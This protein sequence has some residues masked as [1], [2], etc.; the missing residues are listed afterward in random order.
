[1]FESNLNKNLLKYLASCFGLIQFADILINRSI[2]PE[3]SINF[4]LV[5]SIIGF[6]IIIIRYYFDSKSKDNSL[7]ARINVKSS[8]LIFIIFLFSISNIFFIGSAA[9][10]K[11]LNKEV[12]PKINKLIEDENY[13]DAF[14]L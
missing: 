6:I 14:L 4:L 5:A 13:F 7:K 9:E 2:I 3:A 8:A 1:M 11:K 12:I 10:I